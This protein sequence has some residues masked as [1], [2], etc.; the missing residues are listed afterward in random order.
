MDENFKIEQLDKTTLEFAIEKAWHF[1]LNCKNTKEGKTRAHAFS[2]VQKILTHFLQEISNTDKTNPEKVIIHKACC[3]EY[4][5]IEKNQ[6]SK[7]DLGN[8]YTCNECNSSCDVDILNISTT[9]GYFNKTL[10]ELLETDKESECTIEECLIYDDCL[11]VCFC[12]DEQELKEELKKFKKT[13][14][15]LEVKEVLITIN[16]RFALMLH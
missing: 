8:C 4:E 5:L 16:E 6:T 2:S 3:G 1:E 15:K 12:D 11:R 7:D 9:Q 10:D 14:P 13:F